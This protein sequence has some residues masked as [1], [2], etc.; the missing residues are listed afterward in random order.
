MPPSRAIAMAMSDSVTVSMAALMRGMFSC[1]APGEPGA[2]IHVARED[3]GLR[4]DKENVVVGEC[5][6]EDLREAW[7]VV[8]LWCESE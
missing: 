1:N 6:A 5:F 4:R 3:A 2:D 8:V 7:H